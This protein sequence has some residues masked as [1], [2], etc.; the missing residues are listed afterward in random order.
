M[1]ELSRCPYAPIAPEFEPSGD[2]GTP[3]ELVTLDFMTSLDPS[4]LRKISPCRRSAQSTYDGGDVAVNSCYTRI[5]ICPQTWDW[6]YRHE[7]RHRVWVS[8]THTK[9]AGCTS[10]WSQ[11]ACPKMDSSHGPTT[12]KVPRLDPNAAE[13]AVS[14][15]E[16]SSA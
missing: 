15:R 3:R 4:Q 9:R 12:G 2:Y 16:G 6:P 11:C 14:I 7:K 1:R 10:V 5:N 13:R 8:G